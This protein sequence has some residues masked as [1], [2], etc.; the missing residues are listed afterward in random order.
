[1]TFVLKIWKCDDQT[2]CSLVSNN[3]SFS[4]LNVSLQM[5]E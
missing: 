4:D 1:M 3:L 2:I 5:L